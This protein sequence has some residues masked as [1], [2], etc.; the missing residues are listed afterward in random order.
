MSDPEFRIRVSSTPIDRLAE[1]KR[2]YKPSETSF[3][4]TWKTNHRLGHHRSKPRSSVS[5]QFGRARLISRYPPRVRRMR[6]RIDEEHRGGQ[7]MNEDDGQRR[8]EIDGW[9][10]EIVG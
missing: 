6:R 2:R 4:R 9:K 8:R 10:M 3:R 7:G 5:G 1:I